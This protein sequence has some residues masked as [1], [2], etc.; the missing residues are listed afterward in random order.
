MKRK[1]KRKRKKK[2]ENEHSLNFI[3][4]PIFWKD[5]VER[6][7]ER[8]EKKEERGGENEKLGFTEWQ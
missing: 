2:D 1:Q 3:G 6:K 8:E 5:R 4:S 7:V